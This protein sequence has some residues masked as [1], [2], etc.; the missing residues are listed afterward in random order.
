MFSLLLAATSS[1]AQPVILEHRIP[2]TTEVGTSFSM[3]GGVDAW[4]DATQIGPGG[5]PTGEAAASAAARYSFQHTRVSASWSGVAQGWLSGFG[6][7]GQTVRLG[8]H[9]EK[10]PGV[11]LTGQASAV[12]SWREIGS[13]PSLELGGIAHIGVLLSERRGLGVREWGPQIQALVSVPVHPRVRVLLTARQHTYVG[14]TLPDLANVSAGVHWNPALT[15]SLDL[16]ASTL[17]TWGGV[18][19][20]H[21]GLPA[22]GATVSRAYNSLR[23]WINKGVAIQLDAGVEA[24]GGT[25]TY[26]RM[27]TMTGLQV[28]MGRVDAP[29][30]V[31]PEGDILLRFDT[32]NA[33]EVQVAGTFNNWEP[34]AMTRVAERWEL[35]L[36]L[37]PGVHEYVYLVDGTPVVPPEATTTRTDDFGGRNGVLVVSRSTL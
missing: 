25:T 26:T 16:G 31:L 12:Q 20:S 23:W 19:S 17:A 28:S 24:G 6:I 8:L 5:G 37:A 34:M 11:I 33:T 30:I 9:N 1:Q 35:Q 14:D 7:D 18:T 2:S 29:P 32:E 13:G 10:G 4:S 15:W 36:D 22:T 21:A 3:L 27:Y